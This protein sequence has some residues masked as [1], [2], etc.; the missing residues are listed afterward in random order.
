MSDLVELVSNFD[1]SQK[2]DLNSVQEVLAD[3]HSKWIQNYSR[4][5]PNPPPPIH[6]IAHT[7]LTKL[8]IPKKD[9]LEGLS[10]SKLWVKTYVLKICLTN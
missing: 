5:Y 10:A 1:L 7:D 2:E 9:V 6:E 4:I 8:D 3:E